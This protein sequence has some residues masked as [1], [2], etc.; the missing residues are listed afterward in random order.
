MSAP[1]MIAFIT[2]AIVLVFACFMLIRLVY[3]TSFQTRILDNTKY[4]TRVV[5]EMYD[6]LPSMEK[7]MFQLWRFSWKSYLPNV[8]QLLA[9][10]NEWE[11]TKKSYID[12][13]TKQLIAS[14][15]SEEEEQNTA[16]DMPADGYIC[17]TAG[18]ECSLPK[19]PDVVAPIFVP[20]YSSGHIENTPAEKKPTFDLIDSWL[21]ELREFEV[22]K[23]LCLTP[24][25]NPSNKPIKS[26]KP[27]YWHEF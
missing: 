5:L 14:Y 23:A 20:N 3:V 10:H 22:Q 21:A 4:P 15:Q 7:M 2:L 27:R 17:S 26:K 16:P 9:E 18:C 11:D 19:S 8:N 24:F 6:A 1:N 12:D 25:T 13:Q